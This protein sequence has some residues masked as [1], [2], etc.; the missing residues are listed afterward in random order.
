MLSAGE[1]V[2]PDNM[3][4]TCQ[5]V[6]D[7]YVVTIKNEGRTALRYWI[8]DERRTVF[9]YAPFGAEIYFRN[10]GYEAEK[11]RRNA[12]IISQGLTLPVRMENLPAGKS[13]SY[14]FRVD[15]LLTGI[16][17]FNIKAA[18]E[19]GVEYKVLIQ[20]YLSDDMKDYVTCA[21][22]WTKF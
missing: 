13:K 21:S 16:W 7:S 1:V 20:I 4:V 11:K 19:A 22:K 9:F 10:G 14:V 12:A 8:R 2:M 3:K 6:G 17:S 5:I 18:H 15:D